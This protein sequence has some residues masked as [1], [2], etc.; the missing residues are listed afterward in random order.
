MDSVF[1]DLRYAVRNLVRRPGFSALAILTLAVG[2]GVNTVAFTAVNAVLFSPVSALKDVDRFGWAMLSTAGNRY[3]DLSWPEFAELE[4]PRPAFDIVVALGRQPLALAADGHAEQ[5]WALL[6]SADYFR[7]LDARAEVGRL[8]T[9]E[10]SRSPDVVGVVSHR[11]W[12]D[13]M[14]GGSLAGRTLTI[15]N[16][17]VSIVGVLPDG[18]R[19]PRGGTFAPDI[20]LPLERV[21]TFNLRETLKSAEERWLTTL[22]RLAPGVTKPQA[23]AEL[24]AL[25]AHL[26]ATMRRGDEPTRERTLRFLPMSDG[27]PE[28]R[29]LAPAV[30]IAMSI[31][32]V[33]LLIACFNVAA[34]LMARASERQREIATRTALGASRTRIV[35]QLL[36]EGLVLAVPSGVAALI[37]AAWTGRMLAVF[38]LPA[39]IPQE[40][41]LEI[42]RRIVGF[43]SLLVFIAGVLPGLLPALQATRRNIARS[44]RIDA[45]FGD[46]GASR[47]RSIFVATQVAVSTVLLAVAILFV[48]SFLTAVSFDPGFDTDHTVVAQLQPGLHGY[49]SARARAFAGQLVERLSAAPNVAAVSTADHVPFFVGFAKGDTVSRRPVVLYSI[50][51]GHFESLGV[52]L[53]GGRDFSEAE[54]GST[55]V[56]IAGEAFAVREWP[57]ESPIGRH[58][59]LDG[60]DRL[61]QVIGVAADIKHRDLAERAQPVLYQPLTAA[62]FR[63]GFSVVVRGTGDP[64]R[65]VIAMRDALHAVAPALPFASVQTMK[66]RMKLPL[67]PRRTLAGFFLICGSLAL[68][69]AMVGLFG[70]TYYTVRQRTREFGIRIALGARP[71]DVVRHVLGE[72]MRVAV[73]GA[74]LGV[75]GAMVAARL[76]AGA[77]FGVNPADPG[78]YIAAAAI[79]ATVALVACALPARRAA[80]ADPIVALRAE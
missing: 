10:D 53:R 11:F 69:L 61:V 40:I 32:G 3:G 62:D 9:A 47:V 78:N 20:W 58:V 65:L 15:S 25:A 12:R 29:A 7:A 48:R 77:L 6:V 31:V 71:S 37:L 80:Q 57:G 68:L 34:L 1:L 30:W 46:G 52:P 2:I 73:P 38:S 8:L 17:I 43:T 60:S 75:L 18:F 16:R 42:D 27:R 56:V 13:R 39:P 50:S 55:T 21:G 24:A 74:L 45:A 49:D 76:L 67:W 36:T 44:L 72:G 19:G 33:V 5:I 4:R 22:V 79:E 51:P 70:V 63:Q 26:S 28:I 64:G 66:E 14:A 35:R 41:I 54:H 23:D 59:R